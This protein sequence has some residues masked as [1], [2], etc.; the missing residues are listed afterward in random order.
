MVLSSDLRERAISMGAL[1]ALPSTGIAGVDAKLLATLAPLVNSKTGRSELTV[2]RQLEGG[3]AMTQVIRVTIEL[4]GES[5]PQEADFEVPNDYQYQPP[6]I[7][8]PGGL[9]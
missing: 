3:P 1:L 4:S 7:G 2:T 8:T 5:K 9:Q 6:V